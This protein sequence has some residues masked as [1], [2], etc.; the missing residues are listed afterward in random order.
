MVNLMRRSFATQPLENGYDIR[1]AQELLGHTDFSTSMIYTQTTKRDGWPTIRRF[2]S[3]LCCSAAAD[4][5]YRVDD[6]QKLRRRFD[7]VFG[8]FIY[9]KRI[10]IVVPVFGNLKNK[11]MDRF[12]LRGNKKVNTQ[13]QL[14]SLVHN[15]EKI[16]HAGAA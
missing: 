5:A 16:G 10:A 9:N 2:S 11:G 4:G 12:T 7:I 15:I 1:T 6:S 8:R 14:F 13:W 3:R